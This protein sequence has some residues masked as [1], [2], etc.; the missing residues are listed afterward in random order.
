MNKTQAQQ[1]IQKAS[2]LIKKIKFDW[3]LA[4][5][6]SENF[7]GSFNLLNS[8]EKNILEQKLNF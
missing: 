6:D 4:W 3:K 2:D 1:E 5:E 7:G 8:I